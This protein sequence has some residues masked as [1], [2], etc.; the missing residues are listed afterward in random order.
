MFTYVNNFQAIS[1]ASL[2]TSINFDIYDVT[3]VLFASFKL[4]AIIFLYDIYLETTKEVLQNE[5]ERLKKLP[6]NLQ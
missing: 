3:V 5:L 2:M 1:A 4:N 6:V